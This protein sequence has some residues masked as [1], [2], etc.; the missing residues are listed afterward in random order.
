MVLIDRE[1]CKV[2]LAVLMLAVISGHD[3]PKELHVDLAVT[4]PE[5]LTLA[6]EL[7]ELLHEQYG[8]MSKLLSP[9]SE[10]VAVYCEFGELSRSE[11]SPFTVIVLGT[12][13]SV[14]S[15]D[16]VPFLLL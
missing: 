10:V 4:R 14:T 6:T 1:F 3:V 5:L 13:L 11:V 2:V 16:P 12:V 8:V 9:L 7:L 15:I